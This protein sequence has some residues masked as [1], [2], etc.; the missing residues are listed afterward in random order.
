M[1]DRKNKTKKKQKNWMCG[2]SAMTTAPTNALEVMINLPLLNIS[3]K[4]VAR[5]EMNSSLI[6]LTDVKVG[7]HHQKRT[8]N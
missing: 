3:V 6:G 8:T 5:M 7:K 1:T 4:R 2:A